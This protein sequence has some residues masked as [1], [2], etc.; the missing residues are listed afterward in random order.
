MAKLMAPMLQAK[1]EREKRVSNR[2][3]LSSPWVFE[4]PVNRWAKRKPKKMVAS[5]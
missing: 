5:L 2:P 4:S 1:R 3:V